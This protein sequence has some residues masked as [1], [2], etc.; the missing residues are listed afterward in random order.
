[1]SVVDGYLPLLLQYVKSAHAAHVVLDGVLG[2][3]MPDTGKH[4]DVPECLDAAV[5]VGA[6]AVAADAIALDVLQH[7][8][9]PGVLD[10]G[11]YGIAADRLVLY[12]SDLKLVEPAQAFL[13]HLQQ[14]RP[15]TLSDLPTPMSVLHLRVFVF[16]AWERSRSSLQVATVPDATRSLGI[17][18][19]FAP[20]VCLPHQQGVLWNLPASMNH[21]HSHLLRVF[22][23]QAWERIRLSFL[24]I[25]SPPLLIG[26]V[27]P[28]VIFAVPR[29]FC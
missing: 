15:V 23:L 16:Q 3:V 13:V 29:V 27:M 25:R 14:L 11:H 2:L 10:V 12:L 24:I 28:R 26:I 6:E 5:G 9:H 22:V 7:L 21:R 1:M 17:V 20:S 19:R 18:L 8:R 4:L